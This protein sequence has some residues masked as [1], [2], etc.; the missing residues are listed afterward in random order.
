MY[1]KNVSKIGRRHLIS[2][3]K[4]GGRV[5]SET[6]DG[7]WGGQDRKPKTRDRSCGLR[8]QRNRIEDLANPN[9]QP[10]WETG[11]TGDVVRR[12]QTQ[13]SSPDRKLAESKTNCAGGLPK[14][15]PRSETNQ[16]RPSV[17]IAAHLYASVDYQRLPVLNRLYIFLISLGLNCC[18]DPEAGTGGRPR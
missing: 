14:A 6:R 3:T 18:H 13:Q 17:N 10:G 12:P 5:Q 4:G 1:Q 9:I 16:D 2:K 7:D 8:D 15:Q 11:K